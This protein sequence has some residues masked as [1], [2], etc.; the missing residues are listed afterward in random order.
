MPRRSTKKTNLDKHLCG[1]SNLKLVLVGHEEDKAHE[2]ISLTRSLAM[3]FLRG[4]KIDRGPS[5]K[6]PGCRGSC[7]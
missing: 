7:R 5:N 6:S 4:L 2:D 1:L 3:I